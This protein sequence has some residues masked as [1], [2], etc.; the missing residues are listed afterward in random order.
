MKLRHHLKSAVAV[1]GLLFVASTIADETSAAPSA[2]ITDPKQALTTISR[3]VMQDLRPGSRNKGLAAVKATQQLRKDIEKK[4]AT[5]KMTVKE[6][7]MF[8]RKEEP[9]VNR[10]RVKA[11][12]DRIRESGAPVHVHLMA[13]PALSEQ[14]KLAKIDRGTRIIATGKISTAEI[15]SRGN[16]ELHIHLMDATFE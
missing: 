5:F 16:A 14:S 2:E 8:Q 12:I 6:V 4:T 10:F 3:D 9:T 7:E 15:L 11:S 13:I 1:V